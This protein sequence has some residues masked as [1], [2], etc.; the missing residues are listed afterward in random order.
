MIPRK[1]NFLIFMIDQVPQDFFRPGHPCRM[2]R[3]QALA[4]EGLSFDHAYTPSPHCCPARATFMTGLYPTRHGV[5]NNIDTNTAFQHNLNPGVKVF[6][7]GLVDSGYRCALAGK[8]HITNDRTPGDC[9]MTEYGSFA[10]KE[11]RPSPEHP[12]SLQPPFPATP[13]IRRKG[14]PDSPARGPALKDV[15]VEQTPWY[16]S[17]IEPGIQALKDL[18][19]QADPWCL[20]VSTDMNYGTPV[21]AEI[22][23]LYDPEKIEL[24]ASHG[25]NLADKPRIYQRMR[26]Q[27]WDQLD[28]HEKKKSLAHYYALCTLQDRY[29]G[30]LLDALDASGQADDTVALFLSDHGDYGFAHG[31]AHMGIPGFRQAYNVPAVM[32]WPNGIKN[33]G[34]RV[35]A[36]VTLA[37]F[38]PTFLDL[39]GHQ[40]DT[41]FTGRSLRPHLEDQPT[42]PDWPDAVFSQTKGNECYFT[43]RIV[44]TKRHKYVA[45]WFDYDEL[46]DLENDPDE[47]VNL[48][49]PKEADLDPQTP[50]DAPWPPLSPE[51]DAVRKD[52][53]SRMWRFA[54]SQDDIVFNSYLP[55]AFPPYGPGEVE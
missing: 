46:Y 9:G 53:L 33:P 3:V 40:S 29:F 4:R 20:F 49:F 10:K 38:A 39:A 28:E 12:G 13:K 32:R 27:L 5:F 50:T 41:T 42:P 18:T 16:A 25:D 2:D 1:P 44:S 21:P 48:A 6:S 17:T 30:K 43:Q 52:L 45:N 51:W 54:E 55:V 31:L 34:R 37:D 35:E 19:A 26:R 11:K 22:A 24:P 15:T 7:E 14:W 36:F 47:M 8:W 23:A